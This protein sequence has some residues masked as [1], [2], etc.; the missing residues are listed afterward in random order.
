MSLPSRKG[1]YLEFRSQAGYAL[2]TR[3]LEDMRR[4]IRLLNIRQVGKVKEEQTL[5]ATVYVP[6]GKENHFLKKVEDYIEEDTSLGKKPKN[7]KL[8]NSIEEIKIA[9]L[10]ALWTDPP[11]LIPSDVPNWC[12]VWLRVSDDHKLIVENFLKTL[13]SLDIKYKPNYL[14]F[15]ERA[16]ILIYGNQSQ[17]TELIA[18]NDS[19]AELRIAQEAAGFWVRESSVEQQGWIEELLSRIDI[20]A[21]NVK[22][23]LLDTGINNE[24][25]L[26][27]PVL[28]DEDCLTVNPDWGVYDHEG[29]GGHGTLMGGIAIYKSL[30]EALASMERITLTHKLCSVKI[31][32]NPDQ[33]QTPVELW[34]EVTNQGI[35]RA[36]IKLP[37]ERIVF[38][39]SVTAKEGIDRG[40]PSS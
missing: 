35:S 4:G 2:I 12:E 1:T 6:A 14:L 16:V 21:S 9:F 5:L 38:C 3:S 22:V 13:S 29:N 15:P 7:E 18:R 32:P 17:L 33:K 39:L 31:L 24:H 26:I 8:V 20:V 30:E 28:P 36:E 27:K 11:D 34:G 25:K 37:E 10:K 40:R 23:C 19:L